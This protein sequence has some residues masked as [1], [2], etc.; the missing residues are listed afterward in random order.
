MIKTRK[1][2]N[3]IVI[4]IMII[5]ILV[6]MLFA[7]C[8]LNTINAEA[9][10]GVATDCANTDDYI[11]NGKKYNLID[12]AK[13]TIEDLP[14]DFLYAN[15]LNY[16]SNNGLYASTVKYDKDSANT[17]RMSASGDD[18]I[19]QI[20]PKEF[21][22]S[23][24]TGKIHVGKEYGFFI[25]TRVLTDGAYLS[26][27]SVF[28]F[29]NQVNEPELKDQIRFNVKHLFQRE[30]VYFSKDIKSIPTRNC[31]YGK[32]YMEVSKDLKNN[33]GV[34]SSVVDMVV[35]LPYFLG[36]DNYIFT[37][38]QNYYMTNIY[39]MI[40]VMNEQH[41]N[42]GDSNYNVFS[43]KGRFIVQQDIEY[44]AK[45]HNVNENKPAE[46][47]KA[48]FNVA[49]D[50][51][52]S[53]IGNFIPGYSNINFFLKHALDFINIKDYT[54]EIYE[55]QFNFEPN[56]VTAQGFI[57]EK[58]KL[59]RMAQSNLFISEDDYGEGSYLYYDR[60]DY[61]SSAYWLGYTPVESES[62]N[63]FKTP[64]E[65]RIKR[66]FVIQFKSADDS[67]DV[68]TGGNIHDFIKQNENEREYKDLNNDG[69]V[70]LLPNGENLFKYTPERSGTYNIFTRGA[71]SS[72]RLEQIN[73][74]N[75]SI[76]NNNGFD[77]SLSIDMQKDNTYYFKVTSSQNEE[78]EIFNLYKTFE[79]KQID[80]GENALELKYSDNYFKFVPEKKIYYKFNLNK[81][82]YVYKLLNKD[83]ITIDNNLN[84]EEIFVLNA[85]E[86]YYILIDKTNYTEID[87]VNLIV[88]DEVHIYLENID[89]VP[90]LDRIY[91]YSS[92][93]NTDLPK[94]SATGY[95]FEGWW[96]SLE[97]YGTCVTI[98]NINQIAN[99]PE[100]TL[101]AKWT[102]I[103]YIVEYVTNGGTEI[104]NGKYIVEHIYE[105]RTDTYK[106]GYIFGGWFDNA[107]LE[108]HSIERIEK[109]NVG[110]RIFY[111]K[112]IKE[113]YIITLQINKDFID[114][115]DVELEQTEISVKL[116]QNYSL[117]VP[118][119]DGF[120][121]AGWFGGKIQYT[122]NNG[123]CLIPF[124]DT[125]NI[126][127][128]AHWTR[129]VVYFKV[130]NDN[131]VLWLTTKGDEFVLSSDK[132]GLKF[133]YGLC[134]NC[135]IRNQLDANNEYSE[136]MRNIL[137]RIGHFYLY[138]SDKPNSNEIACWN[139]INSFNLFD[140]NN[141]FELY[142]QYQKEKYNI[143]IMKNNI[144][145]EY[146]QVEFDEKLTNNGIY[147]PNVTTEFDEKIGYHHCGFQVADC[148]EN[149]KFEGGIFEIGKEF[150]YAYMP[151]LSQGFETYDGIYSIYLSA[152]YEANVYNINLFDG[153]NL[154]AN[155]EVVFDAL[156]N[157]SIGNAFPIPEKLGFDF[158]GWW[159]EQNGTGV[160]I[161]DENGNLNNDVW[162]IPKDYRLFAKFEY[163]KYLIDFVLDGGEIIKNPPL[164]YTMENELK[165]PITSKFGY[166]FDG[167][168]NGD[169]I[170]RTIPQG[171]T[172]NLVL[173]AN[174]KGVLTNINST[175]EYAIVDE[176]AIIDLS[177]AGVSTKVLIQV[178][179]SVKQIS[180]I[181][182]SEKMMSKS[183]VVDA[184]TDELIMKLKNIDIVGHDN[185]AAIYALECNNLTLE[186]VGKNSLQSGNIT[187]NKTDGAA[188]TC[189]NIVI[190]GEELK[191]T[192]ASAN[193]NIG[194]DGVNGD[195]G[196]LGGGDHP[197]GV[198]IIFIKKLECQ[199]GNGAN[200]LTGTRGTDGTTPS[201]AANGQYG[202]SG[203]NG[204]KG[205]DGGRGGNGGYGILFW[206]EINIKIDASVIGTGGNGGKGGNGGQGGNGGNG[207]EGGDAVFFGP[208]GK[209]GGDGGN[210]GNGGFYGEGGDG[211]FGLM[212]NGLS[213]R[214]SCE[215]IFGKN[216]DIGNVGAGGIGGDGGLGGFY[217][218]KNKRHASGNRG[219]DGRDGSWITIYP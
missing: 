69:Q 48:W 31:N 160:M 38:V 95:V 75:K 72:I 180:F 53:A 79:P 207:G 28:D 50:V 62:G 26:T 169:D 136:L 59:S 123:E 9:N 11:H 20:I 111:A 133:S 105:L 192:G 2:V 193:C 32:P 45:I 206:G 153:E 117:P 96:T 148:L 213:N 215:D 44:C 23:T 165:L 29:I 1:N 128:T 67:S 218:G 36:L 195:A 112:W 73:T 155:K 99:Q 3:K 41:L 130:N 176:I 177:N 12:Y 17:M 89:K 159:T 71:K 7:F 210:G 51:L 199:G 144:S 18:P 64:W 85:G 151:D 120:V 188:L 217:L 24:N 152:L 212:Y 203:T 147:L 196:I 175:G 183:I 66:G 108:G 141:T 191:V 167:W 205:G 138:M 91:K 179:K 70:V 40:S 107:E 83:F 57:E 194:Q 106:E 216:G 185:R 63:S 200:G 170:I 21:F 88:M 137:K 202:M 19:V 61:F 13:S 65:A 68:V 197:E 208:S 142:P 34:D 145:V 37:D 168:I 110:N 113:N 77:E 161:T 122:Y 162:D 109:G 154:Y 78:A 52:N 80:L 47:G 201:K 5:A 129:E 150:A 14:N 126:T 116:N 158:K 219:N 39:N 187:S 174:W 81:S 90:Q 33:I 156:Y 60:N 25:K 190:K 114:G 209:D 8:N 135:F 54:K 100:I 164:Y 35:P 55:K 131:E 178:S 186:C 149:K 101:F 214:G 140:S 211:G 143:Y 74:Q 182:N 82:N 125:S 94:I 58:G 86:T 49:F 198:M 4:S 84:F 103:E 115:L 97:V 118:K 93:G 92:V 157:T 184:R 124:Y 173:T 139:N 134:P 56:Y 171:S 172:G 189:K 98:Q 10:V 102:A 22:T 204:G 46:V 76:V 16:Y 163:T 15:L 43:D 181:G 6:A 87:N 132:S 42:D 119:L 121:F 30:Y 27:V 127:L 166:I 104:D 146:F